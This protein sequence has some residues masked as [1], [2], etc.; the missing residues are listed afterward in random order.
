MAAS[1][2]GSQGRFPG[3][4]WEHEPSGR[5]GVSVERGE[6]RA[7]AHP[8][9]PSHQALAEGCCH[10]GSWGIGSPPLQAALL[11]EGLCLPGKVLR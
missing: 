2:V 6:V 5:R 4:Q 1:G 3:G 10:R 9:F 7:L 11:A 8:T